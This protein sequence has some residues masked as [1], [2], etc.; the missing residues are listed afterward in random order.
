MFRSAFVAFALA[1]PVWG[2]TVDSTGSDP[3]WGGG[4][5]FG[6]PEIDT[7]LAAAGLVVLVGGALIL[8]ARRRAGGHPPSG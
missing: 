8:L 6:A 2:Q 3:F 4:S 5:A 7:K 1:V